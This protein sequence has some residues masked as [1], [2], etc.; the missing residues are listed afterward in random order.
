MI[1]KGRKKQLVPIFPS[2]PIPGHRERLYCR[3]THLAIEEMRATGRT[4]IALGDRNTAKGKLF[5]KLADE[6]ESR[7]LQFATDELVKE[8]T[9]NLLTE[10]QI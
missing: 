3:I 10:G 5:L 2:F 9:E 4:Y 1:T 6:V 7:Q 8:V